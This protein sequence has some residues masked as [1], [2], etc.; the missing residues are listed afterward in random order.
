[1]RNIPP[2]V[3]RHCVQTPQLT[4]A[5]PARQSERQ[6]L[7]H[8]PVGAFAV[9]MGLAGTAVAWL[10]A[11][12]LWSVP[13]LVGRGLAVFALA[14]FALVAV[15]YAVKV[16]RH[17]GAVIAEW[18][19]PVKSA[20][21]ATI[22]ISLLVLAIGFLEW[23]PGFAAALWWTG[24]VLQ[25]VVTLW[26]VRT[27][28]AD[29][30]IEHVHIHPAWFIPAVGNIVAPIAGSGF[31][32]PAVNWYFFG[33]GIVYWLGLLPIVLSRLFTVGTLPPR[34]SPTL[35]ILI[36][37]PAVGAL[38]WVRLGGSFDD[39]LVKIL[40]GVAVFQL[41]LLAVQ[42]P[43]LR[44]MPFAISSWAYSFPLAALST[45][46]I[47]SS[48]S[49]GIDYGWFAALVLALTT[50][51]VAALAVRTGIAVARHEICRPE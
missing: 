41:L 35:A 21:T 11:A 9:V 38:A 4:S 16:I 32:P 37:P 44:Q 7:E 50:I 34:L 24:A 31:A 46:L 40:L 20:F 28:I 33:I 15:A 19:H 27:W 26:V 29:A 3:Y 10:K 2:G 8:F 30:R 23:A 47:G 18:S 39:P 49:G 48:A 25:A 42:A 51:V 12:A 36:A 43:A 14:V 45:G 1:M 5:A 6:R 22:P 17:R 13:P